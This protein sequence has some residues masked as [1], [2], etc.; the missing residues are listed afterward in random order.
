M[1]AVV[2]WCINDKGKPEINFREKRNFKDL[3]TFKSEEKNQFS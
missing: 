2:E 1:N 3:G